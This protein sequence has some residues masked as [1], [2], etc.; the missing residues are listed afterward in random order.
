M[1]T[2]GA[3][4]QDVKSVVLNMRNAVDAEDFALASELKK[5]RDLAR[6]LLAQALRKAAKVAEVVGSADVDRAVLVCIKKEEDDCSSDEA[7]CDPLRN[8]AGGVEELKSP[9]KLWARG[10]R[11]C[12]PSAAQRDGGRRRR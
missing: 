6:E 5:K 12:V 3:R 10:F 4:I 1:Q 8:A 2:V 9:C 11:M 7:S